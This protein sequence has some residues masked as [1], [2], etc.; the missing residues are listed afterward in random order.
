MAMNPNELF[1]AGYNPMPWY[2][3]HNDY[4]IMRALNAEKQAEKKKQE[5]AKKGIIEMSMPLCCEGCIMKV[6]KKLKTMDGVA[7]VEC[8]QLKQKVIVKGDANPEA[9]LKKA[10]K[11]NK[12][13]DFWKEKK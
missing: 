7:S 11:I 9:V 6:H 1:Y 5:D 12:R 4:W 13:A 2:N 3:G 10:R 8:D